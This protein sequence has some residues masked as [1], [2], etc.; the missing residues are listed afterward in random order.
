SPDVTLIQLSSFGCGLDAITTDQV[1][2][3][4]EDHGR[5]YTML[6]LDEV[7]NLGS[8]RIRLRSLLAALRE[9][10][11]P[12]FEPIKFEQRPRFTEECRR[13]HTILAPQMAPIHFELFKAVMRKYGY[14]VVIPPLPDRKAIDL[15]LEY[16]NNDM[17]YPAIVIIG[18]LLEALKSGSYDPDNTS[19]VLFQTCGAC[20]ATNYMAVLRK[21]LKY[22]GFGQVPVFALH[23]LETDAFKMTVPLMRD[24][25]RAAVMGD[26][27]MRVKNRIEPYEIKKGST[28]ALYDEWMTKCTKALESG[29]ASEYKKVIR[30]MVEAFDSVPILDIPR[31]PRV[32]IVGEILVKYHP[33]ANNGLERE[34]LSEGAEVVMPDFVDFFLYLACDPIVERRLMGGSFKAE[35]WARIFMAI[36][37]H[38]RAPALRAL[39]RSRRFTAP[40]GIFEIMDMASRFVSPGNLAGEGWFLTGEMV[41]LIKEGVPNIVCLQPFGCLPN[42]ITGKGVVH[43]LR[44]AYSD[45]NIVTIDCDAG[46]SEVNQLN[47]LKLMLTVARRANRKAQLQDQEIAF[48]SGS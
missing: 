30:G 13:K 37:S 36:V 29:S 43:S 33:V 42:H 25:I 48:K 24:A 44:Q 16:V 34:L 23:G 10:R 40:E 11:I 32:G 41:K 7:S 26:T 15:G 35:A 28:K 14:N 6:K 38:F 20:R 17:C 47:R 9:R 21:A 39:R 31:L 22:A 5:V 27:L 12:Q 8:A 19:I 1:R 3:I 46:S 4:L 18:Q 2:S 45:A